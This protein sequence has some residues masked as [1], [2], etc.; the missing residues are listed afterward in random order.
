MY[1]TNLKKK[2]K[3]KIGFHFTFKKNIA[4]NV[5]VTYGKYASSSDIFIFIAAVTVFC[6]GLQFINCVTFNGNRNLLERLFKD[7]LKPL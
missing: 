1:H 2:G 5:K 3:T 6:C 7:K 4:N